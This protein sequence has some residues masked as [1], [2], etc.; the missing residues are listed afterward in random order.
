MLMILCLPVMMLIFYMKLKS[1]YSKPFK[2][3]DL[4]EASF[5]LGIEIHRD[6]S[7]NLLGLSQCAYADRVLKRFNMETCKAR[8]V[9][10]L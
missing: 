5:V 6:R 4:G 2:F 3:T 7:Q 1:C 9:P 10:E 8:E